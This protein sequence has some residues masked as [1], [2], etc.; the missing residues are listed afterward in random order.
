MKNSVTI[1]GTKEAAKFFDRVIKEKRERRD[2]IRQK[3]KSGELK[4]S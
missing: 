3:I 4:L 1:Q 2:E